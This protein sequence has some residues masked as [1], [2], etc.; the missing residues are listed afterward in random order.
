MNSQLSTPNPVKGRGPNGALRP[1]PSVELHIEELV[2]D[3]FVPGERYGISDAVERDLARLLG[4]QGIPSSLRSE[5]AID[6]IKGATFNAAHNA[7]PPALGRHIAH[8]V[9]Q[10]LG[11]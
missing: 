6:E 1:Q 4:Q 10:G 2:L 8:A 3:G 9:Y 5:S 11:G 7:K